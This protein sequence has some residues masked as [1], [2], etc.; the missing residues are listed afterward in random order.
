M[1]IRLCDEKVYGELQ[2]FEVHDEKT[3]SWIL[4]PDPF[5]AL[6]AR[7]LR[8]LAMEERLRIITELIHITARAALEV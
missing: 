5:R 3:S 6:R 2:T 8:M 4:T 7:Y 1:G